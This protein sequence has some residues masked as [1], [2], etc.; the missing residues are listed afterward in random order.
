M[1]KIIFLDIDGVLNS[2]DELRNLPEKKEHTIED[3]IYDIHCKALQ[4]IVEKTNAVVVL[5]STWRHSY[6]DLVK[7]KLEK[8]NIKIIDKTGTG[9]NDC[10]RGNLI[11]KW[12]KEHEDIISCKY[13]DYKNY[14]ILD[15]NSDMLYWQKDNF[16]KVDGKTGLTETYIKRAIEILNQE[17]QRITKVTRI[18]NLS[19]IQC[20]CYNCL[21]EQ[22]IMFHGMPIISQFMIVCPICG[23]KRC[24]K[25]TDHRNECTHSNEPGQKGSRY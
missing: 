1:T 6:F 19:E 23:N 12:I 25:A 10:L 18:N 22:N 24:P 16:I 9:C 13:Y 14:L 17:E 7:N 15:D 2:E 4:T 3:E 20:W 5:S 11:Y 21:S 8:Y